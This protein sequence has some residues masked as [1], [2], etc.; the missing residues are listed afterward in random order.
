MSV[1]VVPGGAASDKDEL[2]KLASG[3]GYPVLFKPSDGGGGTGQSVRTRAGEAVL[4][5]TPHTALLSQF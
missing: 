1:P 4:L 3:M 5:G 2:L